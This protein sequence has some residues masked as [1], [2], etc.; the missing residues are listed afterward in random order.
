M[1]RY[2]RK[3]TLIDKK[4]KEYLWANIFAG[5]AMSANVIVDGIIVGNLLGSMALAAIN[6]A[7]PVLLLVTT[8]VAVLGIGGATAAAVQKGERQQRMANIIYTVCIL[9]MLVMGA[10]FF[11]IGNVFFQDIMGFFPLQDESLYVLVGQFLRPIFLAVPLL[12][13]AAV[14]QFFVGADGHPGL[15]MKM[16]MLNSA[17]NL[18]MDVVYIKFFS[19]GIAGAAWA[20]VTGFAAALLVVALFY[21]RRN[22]HYLRTLALCKISLQDVKCLGNVTSLGIIT[23]SFQ[24][25]MFLQLF[26]LNDM[27]LVSFGAV[28]MIALSLCMNCRSLIGIIINGVLDT[29]GPIL[30][31]L[32]GER[33]LQG[34]RFLLK[35]TWRFVFLAGFGILVL[36]EVMPEII[37]TIYGVTAGSERVMSVHALRLFALSIPLS[38]FTVVIAEYYQ[39]IGELKLA[40]F[41]S[42]VEGILG[43][44]LTVYFLLACL[45]PDAIWGAFAL[46][47]LLTVL[48]IFAG[49][50]YCAR[51]S[52]GKKKGVF[53]LQQTDEAAQ[54]IYEVTARSIALDAVQVSADIIKTAK[55]SG[56]EDKICGFLGMAVEEVLMELKEQNKKE[57]DVDIMVRSFDAQMVMAFRDNGIACNYLKDAA[58]PE[59]ELAVSNLGLLARMAAEVKY[60]YVMG[61]NCMRVVIKRS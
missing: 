35:R 22:A 44:V 47:E 52:Q 39:V 3:S 12:T 5:I 49:S 10:G 17:V 60:D 23:A 43:I 34:I 31:M 53:L 55:Q 41:V 25:F 9:T 57:C 56:I 48:V 24:F 50:H 27:V 14:M 51:H 33:D 45:G 40:I 36:L 28:G 8:V 30:G 54:T 13:L 59:K 19:M 11:L 21:W 32:L 58:L 6:I 15:V 20:T 4:F 61:F 7:A 26:F 37:L 29:L 42:F 38:G 18:C 1:I 46:S 2:R 16:A